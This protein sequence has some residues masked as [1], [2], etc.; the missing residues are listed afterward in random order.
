MTVP[1][2]NIP[3]N[4]RLPLFFAEIDPSHANT[5]SIAQRALLIGQKTAAGTLS[6]DVPVIS[7][8]QSETRQ[9]AG[10][11]SILATMIDAYRANDPS[12]EMWV[13]PLADDNAATAAVWT[14]TFSGTSTAA[15]TIPLYVAG[16]LVAVPV[17]SG[18]T[19]AAAATVVAA[20]IT[21][22]I[23]L[24]VTAAVAGAVVTLT[25]R[26][27]GEAA[28]DFDLRTAF[29]GA[30]GNERMPAGL[31]VVFA[32]TVQ[33]ATNPTLTAGL[34]N[35]QDLNFDF[36][37][38]S[39][40]DATSLAA[41]A[42]L[43]NDVDGRWSWQS[44]VYGHCWIAKR[45]T[46]GECATFAAALNNQHLSVIPFTD[47]PTPSFAWAAAFAGACAVSLRADPGLP[48][49]ALTVNNLLA[50]P[51]QS[52]WS[53]AIRNNTLLFSGCSAWDV[54]ATGAIV[55]ENVVTSYVED[56]AGNPDDSYLEVESL[57]GLAFVLRFLRT[58]ITGKFGRKKL[59]PDGTRLLPGSN[60][61][62]P[63]I[64]R[65]ELIAAYRELEEQGHVQQSDVFARDLVVEINATNRNRVDV[66]WP[67]VLI[68]QLRQFALL[69]QFRNG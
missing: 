46:A 59:A 51:I 24:P 69:A 44:Q 26:N 3:A 42:T 65:A 30:A 2:A 63:A 39:L 31:A 62:T 28:N 35:L 36:I 13:L 16:Q 48:L 37:V 22:A 4:L 7:R 58:R 45:G 49:Q 34:A 38:C 60:V 50:P 61:V 41:I 17:A 67:G 5:Q 64:I 11:G 43:L 21:A 52:R 40:T 14:A 27:A 15:G 23:G 47:S 8:S 56:A 19:A 33:G 57:F 66:L 25:A 20:A 10:N 18:T 12:G 68:G 53:Q 55:T 9:A 29:L 54:D 32:Q 6:A 1:F